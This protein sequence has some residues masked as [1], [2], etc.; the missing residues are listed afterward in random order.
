MSQ[1]KTAEDVCRECMYGK[2]VMS[3]LLGKAHK[4]G[5]IVII[6]LVKED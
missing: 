2:L 6:G 1:Q 4:E 5:I 3:G